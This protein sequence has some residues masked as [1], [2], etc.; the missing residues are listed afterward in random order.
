MMA[1]IHEEDQPHVAQGINDSVLSG[2]PFQMVYRVKRGDGFAKITE[3]GKCYRYVDGVAT[4]FTGVVFDSCPA[5]TF[6]DASNVNAP[7]LAD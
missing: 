5:G 7:V 3:M 4:L 6:S 1:L 2:E